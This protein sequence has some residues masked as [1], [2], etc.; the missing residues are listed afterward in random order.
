MKPTETD[1]PSPAPPPAICR[2]AERLEAEGAAWC[3]R[4][5]KLRAQRDKNGL[6][7]MPYKPRERSTGYPC[8]PR[9]NKG[10]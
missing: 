10:P 1:K 7:R 5:L 4:L 8:L 9:Q 6:R 2:D 3:E